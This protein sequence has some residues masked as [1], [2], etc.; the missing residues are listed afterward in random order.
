MSRLMLAFCLLITSAAADEFQLT[1]G[2]Y[3]K[4]KNFILPS[5]REVAYLK[6]DWRSSLGPAI[7]EARTKD[8]PI[9]VWAYNGNPLTNSCHNGVITKPIFGDA[10]VQRLSKDF[11]LVAEDSFRLFTEEKYP[12]RNFFRELVP[13][14]SQGIYVFTPSGKELSE[15]K[16]NWSTVDMGV[17]DLMK[18]SKQR[19]DTMPKAERTKSVATGGGVKPEAKLYPA[20]G[21]VLH[22][23]TR[24]LNQDQTPRSKEWNQDFVWFQ[25]HEAKQFVPTPIKIG[26]QID[27]PQFLVERLARFHLLDSVHGQTR[28]FEQGDVKLA[29]LTSKITSVKNGV[30]GLDFEGETKTDAEGLWGVNRE[31]PSAMRKRGYETRLLGRA[32]VDTAKQKFTSFELVGSGTRWG[33]TEYNFRTHDL[34]QHTPVGAVFVLA[35]KEATEQV[36]PDRVNDYNWQNPEQSR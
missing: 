36:R 28:G 12:G 14:G 30:V 23:Y 34:D 4:W 31:E 32:T 29:R 2:N 24:D 9:L 25:K 15:M 33:G 18:T 26:Q 3:D 5:E 13:T 7:K 10:E 19:W 20:N 8:K 35:G 27:V 11:V 6:L 1:K 16:W 17:I 21:L 22:F